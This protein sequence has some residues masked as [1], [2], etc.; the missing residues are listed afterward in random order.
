MVCSYS[1]RLVLIAVSAGLL[2]GCGRAGV[3]NLGAA[4]DGPIAPTRDGTIV[5]DDVGPLGPIADA[6]PPA[7]CQSAADCLRTMGPRQCANGTAGTWA[8]ELPPGCGAD[9]FGVCNL[10][11]TDPMQRCNSDCDCSFDMACLSGTCRVASRNNQCCTNPNCRPGDICFHPDGRSDR[12]RGTSPPPPYPDAGPGP[13]APDGG[14]PPTD[15]G[16]MPPPFPDTGPRPPGVDGGPSPCRTDCDC[17]FNLSCARGACVPLNRPNLCCANPGCPPGS[18]CVN[19]DGT[20]GTCGMMTGTVPVGQACTGSSDCNGGF[21][22]NMSS[23]FPGG[24]C[25]T[26][27]GGGQMCPG[28]AVCHTLGRNQVCLD[29]CNTNS[30]CRT[31]YGCRR[32]GTQTQRVCWPQ[33]SG[34]MN[35]G[36]DPVGSAC[37]RDDDCRTGLTC[38]QASGRSFPGGYCTITYCDPQTN[39]C[40]MGSQCYAFPQSYSLCLMECPSG[41]SQ[42]TCRTGYYCLGPSGGAGVCVTN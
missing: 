24:Y 10:R 11:C 16:P 39:P 13:P 15:S 31:G 5:P 38:Q 33:S 12:C 28:D 7:A 22:I 8:C 34:S 14:R 1:Y 9:C 17:P 30:D 25:S 32:L 26:G 40:P 2:S 19:P 35:P 18:S 23:G 3:S 36:G 27:C 37:Q 41:G 20:R 21:C 4:S 29:G 42:S 6:G